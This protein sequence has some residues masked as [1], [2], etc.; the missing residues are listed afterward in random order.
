MRPG[1]EGAQTSVLI[2]ERSVDHEL[3]QIG[4]AFPPVVRIRLENAP[5]PG[6]EGFHSEGARTHEGLV[7]LLQRRSVL[8]DGEQVI[9]NDGREIGDRSKQLQ[10]DRSVVA[11]A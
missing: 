3:V 11:L 9:T 2:S 1:L 5:L 8:D 7:L 4:Q 6:N 10:L